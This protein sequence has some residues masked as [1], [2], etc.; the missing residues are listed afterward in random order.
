MKESKTP[1]KKKSRKSHS[2]RRVGAK[3]EVGHRPQ[4]GPCCLRSIGPAAEQGGTEREPRGGAGASTM[5]DT[6]V[7]RRCGGCSGAHPQQKV[8]EGAADDCSEISGPQ[9]TGAGR[10]RGREAH[11][12]TRVDLIENNASLRETLKHYKA[13]P[14]D[15]AVERHPALGEHDLLAQ[16]V[17]PGG[18]QPALSNDANWQTRIVPF[19]SWAN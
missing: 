16:R 9:Q 14:R 3:L 13:S 10:Q 19:F 11:L 1:G 18:S 7:P 15:L 12:G 6:P 17:L 2:A 5:G 4:R 8:Q